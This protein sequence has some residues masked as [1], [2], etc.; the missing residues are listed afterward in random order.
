MSTAN[1]IVTRFAD[2]TDVT[3]ATVASGNVLAY[4]GTNWVNSSDYY[5]K[6]QVDSLISGVGGATSLDDLSD[7]AIGT[8]AAGN[9]LSYNGSAWVNSADYYTKSQVDALIAGAGGGTPGGSSGA[10]QYNNAGA[11]GGFGSWDGTALALAA[12]SRVVFG[13]GTTVSGEI[14]RA[15]SSRLLHCPSDASNIFLGQRSGAATVSGTYNVGIGADTLTGATLSACIGIGGLTLPNLGTG[16]GSGNQVT[17]IGYNVLPSLT[18]GTNLVCVGR[19]YN[20]ATSATSVH[21]LGVGNGNAATSAEYS[22]LA[23][24]NVAA[25]A[26]AL[27]GTTAAGHSAFQYATSATNST[28]FGF[29]AGLALT[30]AADLCTFFGAWAGGFSPTPTTLSKSGGFGYNAQ[31]TSNN[32]IAIGGTGSDAVALVVN[33]TTTTA[34]AQITATAGSKPVLTLK[35][36]STPSGNQFQLIDSGDVA[37]VYVTNDYVVASRNGFRLDTTSAYYQGYSASNYLFWGGGG[38]NSLFTAANASHT[39]A[40]FKAASSQTANLT[41]WQTSGGTVGLA[42]NKANYLL[43]AN[44]SAPADGDLAAGQVALWFDSTNGAA[45]LM[46]K[47]KSANGTVVSGE[48]ALS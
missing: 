31:V 24:T 36:G 16:G 19:S 7:V 20:A 26:T 41:E 12:G 17:A 29:N 2:L 25:T 45:K 18:T 35:S 28:A 21:S 33:G 30:G 38:P 14:L 34:Q 40:C 22:V 5:T 39:V 27:S 1:Y 8:P 10:L 3:L 47:G 13:T 44:N 23:G 11:F 15:G 37:Q 46:V 43:I 6:S 4:D 9:V 32:T 48:V 42:V